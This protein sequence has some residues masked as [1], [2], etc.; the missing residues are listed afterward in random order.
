MGSYDAQPFLETEVFYLKDDIKWETVKPYYSNIPLEH[1][2]AVQSNLE[3]EPRPVKI[4]DLRGIENDLSLEMHG[5]CVYRTEE[6]DFDSLYPNFRDPYWIQESYYPRLEMWMR[7]AI[8]NNKI[9]RIYIY[10]HT[11]SLHRTL[12]CGCS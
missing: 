6:H 12:R 3:S 4:T 2:D 5:F 8:G 7:E 11:V 10:D 9:E 1:P